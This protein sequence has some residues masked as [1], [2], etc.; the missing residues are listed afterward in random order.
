M[1]HM[2][3]IDKDNILKQISDASRR[4]LEIRQAA[5]ASPGMEIG[6]AYKKWKKA[7]GESA[8]M[9]NTS[10][11]QA[12]TKETLATIYKL[13][14]RPCTREGCDG[15]QHLESVCGGCI[16]GKAGYKTKWTCDTCMT[17]ELSKEDINTWI[18]RL[19]SI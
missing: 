4:T 3:T 12:K 7:L 13:R 14:T 19:S 9:L 16:E 5:A 15:T 11:D 18:I 2:A 1:I 6:A 8:E 10:Q 17:R